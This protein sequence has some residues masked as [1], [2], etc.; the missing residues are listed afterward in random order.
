[1][2]LTVALDLADKTASQLRRTVPG[3][4]PGLWMP[5]LGTH[6]LAVVASPDDGG[7]AASA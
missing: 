4:L 6:S 3:S 1:M 7:A 2:T 5:I